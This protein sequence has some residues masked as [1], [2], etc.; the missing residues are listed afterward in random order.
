VRMRPG[1]S[2][3]G[4]I[5]T[6]RLQKVLLVPLEAVFVRPDGP[7]AF[8]RTSVGHELVKLKLGR[9]NWRAVEVLAGLKEGD[10]V[11]RRDLEGAR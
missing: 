11:S 9:R 2:F 6:G 10:R 8:R 4:R 3:R 1:M 7:V 5:E